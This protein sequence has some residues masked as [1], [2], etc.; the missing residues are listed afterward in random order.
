MKGTCLLCT[1]VQS[2]SWGGRARQGLAG[3][4]DQ[5]SGQKVHRRQAPPALRLPQP[6][7]QTE[8]GILKWE[9]DLESEEEQAIRFDFNVEHPH[10]LAE[11]GLP[12][13]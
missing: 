1:V 2:P 10:S 3:T 5:R 6:T 12:R 11:I 4:G 13:D 9:L 8:L 7:Q